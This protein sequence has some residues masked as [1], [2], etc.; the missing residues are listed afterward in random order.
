MS[1]VT[2]GKQPHFRNIAADKFAT[3]DVLRWIW[4]PVSY[5]ACANSTEFNA[6]AFFGRLGYLVKKVKVR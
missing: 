4:P 5:W 6:P 1:A 3:D 2:H